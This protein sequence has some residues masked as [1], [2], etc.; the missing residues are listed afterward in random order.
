MSSY[1]HEANFKLSNSMYKEA[2][3][4]E[5]PLKYVSAIP[6]MSKDTTV[7]FKN[8]TLFIASYKNIC[9][10]GGKYSLHK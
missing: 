7:T 2:D 8:L 9:C 1:L 6:I 5:A 10:L 3:L 4:K